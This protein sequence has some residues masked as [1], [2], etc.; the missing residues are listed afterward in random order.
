MNPLL[1]FYAGILIG[2]PMGMIIVGIFFDP[3]ERAYQQRLD[4]YR[5]GVTEEIDGG[6]ND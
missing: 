1:A 4:R 2:V 5:D 3:R 6:S